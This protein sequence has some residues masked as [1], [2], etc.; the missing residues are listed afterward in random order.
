M[1]RN[2]EENCEENCRKVGVVLTLNN[3][4]CKIYTILEPWKKE[5]GTS[6]ILLNLSS[7]ELKIF[8]KIEKNQKK[9]II[10]DALN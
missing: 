7:R 1:Y 10:Y 4:V 9:T 8:R 3:H 5:Q 2:L 6:G